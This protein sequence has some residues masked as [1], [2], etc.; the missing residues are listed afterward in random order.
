MGRL[1]L[2]INIEVSCCLIGLLVL[3]SEEIEHVINGCCHSTRRLCQ[4]NVG[5]RGKIL[6]NQ[7]CLSLLVVVGLLTLHF[8]DCAG[9]RESLIGQYIE[10]IILGYEL[11]VL[12]GVDVQ[13]KGDT[14]RRNLVVH[15]LFPQ[16]VHHERLRLNDVRLLSK[17]RVYFVLEK[18]LSSI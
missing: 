9:R 2:G 10:P 4:F 3:H 5:A 14:L 11:V 8:F 7:G 18:G 17:L 6:L 16:D 1:W 13:V 15:V 12:F